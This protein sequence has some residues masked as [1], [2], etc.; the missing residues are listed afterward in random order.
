MMKDLKIFSLTNNCK[1][2]A[3]I[4]DSLGLG[5]SECKIERF[6]DG[7][8]LVSGF[9][10][11]RGSHC[12]IVQPTSP[13]NVNESIMEL[14]ILIDA[15]KRAD[16][17]TICAVIPYYGYARQ[18]RKC[19]PR[20]PITSKLIATLLEAAGV[21]RVMVM[22]LHASQIQGFFDV[23]IDEFNA[24][25]ILSKYFI[26][27]NIDDLTIVSPDHGGA[28]RAKKM[29]ELLDCP[30]AIIDKQRPRPNESEVVGIIGDVKGKNCIIVDDMIDTGGSIVNAVA[31]LKK[32]GAKDVYVTCSH[33]LFSG[34]ASKRLSNCEA[35]E[36]VVTDTIALPKEKHFDK[37][38]VL[39]TAELFALGIQAVYNQVSL[40]DVIK[41]HQNKILNK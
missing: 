13:P 25:P 32:Q 5:V 17:K 6:A 33:A 41:K 31:E 16:A 9:E 22:D 37:L 35:V 11:V 34:E 23:Q 21:T 24:L 36:V 7:E 4:A 12:Y 40:G 2:A 18:D 1:L 14:L 26:E 19:K 39:S 8:V 27:K 10:S 30:I 3:D 20:Q 28:V 38:V 29:S 15:L